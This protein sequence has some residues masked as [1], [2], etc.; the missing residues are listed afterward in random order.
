MAR[1]GGRKKARSEKD[2]EQQRRIKMKAQL[3]K[4]GAIATL[5]IVLIGIS[6]TAQSKGVD[7]NSIL[8]AWEQAITFRDCNTGATLRTRP[9]LISFMFGG[10]MQE[11]GTGQQIPQ[12]RTDGQGTWN[13]DTARNYSSV[14]KAFRF[15]ADGSLA[16]T[17]KLYRQIELSNDGESFNAVV[18]SEIYD[19]NGVLV[20]Q[21]C[22]TEAGTRLQ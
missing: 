17:A 8:G 6:A 16:G 13:H 21:G 19:A 10:V 18:N 9:G 5:T 2:L 12:N 15:N 11:F 3:L 14:S 22:S 4:S 1:I 20:S 7:K